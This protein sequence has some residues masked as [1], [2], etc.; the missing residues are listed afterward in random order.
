MQVKRRIALFA[1]LTTCTLLQTAPIMAENTAVTG[2]VPLVIYEV[3]VPNTQTT[4]A[5]I[6]WKTN[7][8]ATSQ[9]FYDRAFHDNVTGYFFRTDE[10]AGL[11]SQHSVS[12]AALL[13]ST[14]YHYRVRSAM[15]GTDFVAVSDDYTFVT[16]S[17]TIITGGE[18]GGGAAPASSPTATPVAIPSNF[19]RLPP[20]EAAAI[21]EKMTPTQAASLL[22]N[23][24]SSAASAIFEKTTSEKVAAI[25]A[26]MT[27]ERATAFMD[28][29]S[30][31]KLTDIILDLSEAAL[32]ERLPGLSAEKLYSISPQVLFTALPNVPNAQL[33]G[34]KPPEPPS[35][36][37]APVTVYSTPDGARYLTIQTWA[38]EW[39]VVVGTPLPLDKVMIK[40]RSASQNVQTTVDILTGRPPEVTAQLPE[41]AIASNYFEITFENITSEDIQ[42]GYITFKVD[43]I[44]LEQYSINKWAVFL[45]RYDPELLQWIPLPTKKV[46]EDERY[47]YYSAV[48]SHFSIF[49]ITGNQIVPAQKFKA[50]NLAISPVDAK[51][52][53]AVTVSA[54][55]TNPSNTNGTYVSTLW[56]SGSVENGKDVNLKAGETKKISFTLSRGIEGTYSVRFEQLFGQ[57]LVHAS[58]AAQTPVSSPVPT[59]TR[60]PASPRPSAPPVTPTS[61]PTSPVST[62]PTRW[63]L[64]IGIIGGCIVVVSIILLILTKQ[65][66]ETEQ[67]ARK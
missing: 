34:E 36:A 8:N 27:P 15:P 60:T 10:T 41:K 22:E 32:L 6:S 38:G 45:D 4:S 5:T 19:D 16:L 23:M 51:P 62:T 31:T 26:K 17:E 21:V 12:I 52:G 43:K 63:P 25:L 33:V 28:G 49:A 24:N 58:A 65:V 46:R 1:L 57:F 47:V 54:D 56:I 42:L 29:L 67:K 61:K 18:G 14:V 30:T 44:W 48:T 13:S 59:T 40:T 53:E 2:I 50:G 9:V 20:E 55:V 3:S 35:G 66:K 37:T 64:I 7:G 11:V 39:M